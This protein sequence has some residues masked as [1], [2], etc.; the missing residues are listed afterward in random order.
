MIKEKSKTSQEQSE[1][2]SWDRPWLFKPGQSGNPGGR[3]KGSKSLK[4]F[5][6]EYLESLDDDGKLE[7]MRGLDKDIVWKMAEGNPKDETTIKANVTISD[8]LDNLE[9]DQEKG[10][11]GQ[12]ITGQIMEAEPSL[13][14]PEQAGTT[15]SVQDESGPGALPSEQVV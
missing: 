8:M 11:L 6:R 15:D 12:E 2:K 13:S 1:N 5:A 10:S 3:P 7:F 4:T 14:N 9:N